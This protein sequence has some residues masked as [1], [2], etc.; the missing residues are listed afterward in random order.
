MKTCLMLPLGSGRGKKKGG[1]EGKEGRGGAQFRMGLL[2]VVKH[3]MKGELWEK[4]RKE[5]QKEGR[6]CSVAMAKKQD[7]ESA[8]NRR[9]L[10]GIRQCLPGY[11]KGARGLALPSQTTVD[12]PKAIVQRAAELEFGSVFPEQH[13]REFWHWDFDKGVHAYLKR[14]YG[15]RSLENYCNG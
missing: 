4:I 6:A 9:A 15:R 3:C 10:Q 13:G 2:Y 12:K 11:R 14:K 5:I 8:F 7:T 1:V